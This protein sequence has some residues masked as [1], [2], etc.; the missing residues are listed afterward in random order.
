MVLVCLGLQRGFV[1]VE[2]YATKQ[3]KHVMAHNSHNSSVAFVAL[4]YD[5]RL[6]ATASSKGTLVR[7]FSTTDG[8]LLQEVLNFMLNSFCI[9]SVIIYYIDSPLIVRIIECKPLV[10]RSF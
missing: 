9:C 2:Q 10:F 1:R 8:S 6:M 7:V 4:M 5:G 3:C